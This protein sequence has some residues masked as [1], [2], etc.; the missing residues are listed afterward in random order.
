MRISTAGM[1]ESLLQRIMERTAALER[2]QN[3]LAAGKRI[4]TP[5][6]DPSG[7]VRALD[8]DRALAENQQYARNIDAATNR[9]SLEEQTL[10]NTTS[11]LQR[12]RDLIVQANNAPLGPNERAQIATEI[13]SRIRELVDLANTRDAT[14]EYL[15]GGYQT[16]SQPFALSGN[17]VSYKGD[18]GVR[19]IQTG[20]TQRI[21]DSHSGFEV[22]MDIIEGNGT[23]VTAANPAN[24]GSGMI[25]GG[26]V[27]DPNAWIRDTYTIT[28]TSPTDWEVTDSNGNPVANGTYTSPG[29]IEFLGV[30]VT[31]SGEPAANDTFTIRPSAKQDMFTTLTQLIDT[32]RSP[33]TTDAQRAQVAT[34]LGTALA[35]MDR[36]LDHVSSVRAEVGARLSSL[37]QA[38]DTRL[39]RELEMQRSLSELRDLD[40]SE[41]V[42]RLNLQLAGLEAAQASYARLSQLS[43]FDYL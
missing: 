28:F 39:D 19:L 11:L 29:T 23:F 10:A 36:A 3:Q 15:F 5:A 40:Y 38:E 6:D 37:D 9:L 13:E 24:A 35:Q 31:L 7:A 2:T 30:Q 32:L 1:H 42:T 34:R 22:F 18:Q 33:I 14:G 12:V 27:V 20:P 4:L 41:A 16:Q 17:T 8:I 25:D 43:L 26:H 21:A